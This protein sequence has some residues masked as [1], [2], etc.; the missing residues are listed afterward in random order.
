MNRRS[1]TFDGTEY[2]PGATYRVMVTGL[3]LH[4]MINAGPSAWGMWSQD[5][6]PGDILTCTGYGAGFGGDPGYG[7]EFTSEAS[8]TAGAF[9]CDVSPQA[10]DVFSYRP[11]PR[12]LERQD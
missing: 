10:G 6:Q 4:G 5:L 12:S 11:P 9:H 7:V 1:V 2:A 3:K 8:E